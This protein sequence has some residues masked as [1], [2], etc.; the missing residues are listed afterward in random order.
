M[1]VYITDRTG[2]TGMGLFSS[3]KEG[4]LQA[5]ENIRA[6]GEQRRLEQQARDQRLARFHRGYDVFPPEMTVTYS[7]QCRSHYLKG[8]IIKWILLAVF[9]AMTVYLF[10]KMTHPVLLIFSGF[11]SL[12]FF[13][14]DI[15]DLSL[16]LRLIQGDFD[17]FGGMITGK[18]VEEHTSTDSD[19]Q[20]ST[21]YNYFVSLNGI[22][23][24]VS[25]T[26]YRKADE[27]TYCFFVR[28]TAKY[29]RNDMVILYPCPQMIDE[30][31]IIGHHHPTHEIRLY[32]KPSSN[33][34]AVLLGVLGILGA[35]ILAILGNTGAGATLEIYWVPLTA[36]SAAIGILSFVLNSISVHKREKQELEEKR[37]IYDRQ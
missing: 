8:F 12:I 11:A 28:F 5:A 15:H 4:L 18:R 19:G 9:L 29:I 37:K 10:I 1:I 13:L 30:S 20:T 35:I 34:L 6:A 33:G 23:S 2:G 17:V 16:F 32:R 7:K 31:N 36:G 24:E 26:E 3:L 27:E 14:L 25:S 21:S 22:E